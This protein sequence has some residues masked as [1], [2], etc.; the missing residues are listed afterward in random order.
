MQAASTNGPGSS[1]GSK[2]NTTVVDASEYAPQVVE[3]AS[4]TADP[5][6]LPSRAEESTVSHSV[7]LPGRISEEERKSKWM[8]KLQ[9]LRAKHGPPTS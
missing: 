1:R 5:E 6:Q 7:V 3:L 9:M 2:Y 4:P 8:K